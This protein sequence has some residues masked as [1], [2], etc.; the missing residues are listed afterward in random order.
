MIM[1]NTLIQDGIRLKAKFFRGLAD[2]SRLACLEALKAAPRSVGEVVAATG[3][4]QPNVSS[5]LS[6]LQDC[7]LVRSRPEGRRVIYSI[8]ERDVLR[9]LETAGKLLARNSERVYQC[10]RY[11]T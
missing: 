1:N 2:G 9:L 5:H 8:S 4:S 11:R 10:T 7:G 6:C 3:L